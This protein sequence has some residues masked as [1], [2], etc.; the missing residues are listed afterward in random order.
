MRVL[1]VV[2]TDAFAG[3]ER[4]VARLA[5]A[6]SARGH[7]VTVAGGDPGAMAV[8]AP[9][10]RRVAAATV[11]AAAAAVRRAAARTDVVHAHMT[12]AEL[13]T[14]LGLAGLG[15]A[16][17]VVATRH[18]ARRR[19]SGRLGPVVAR[20][21]TH[22]LRAQ[23]A[24][25]R[26]VADRVDGA[27]DGPCIVVPP[28][29]DPAPEPPDAAARSAV[30][31][32]AQRLEAE[33]DTATAVRAFAGSGLAADGWT[34]RVAGDGAQRDEIAR[35]AD[36]LGVRSLVELLGHRGDVDDLMRDAALFLATCPVEGLGLSV[37]EAMRSGLPVV[38]VGA[39]GHL[40]TSGVLDRAPLFDP[41]DHRGAATLLAD[42]AGDLEARRR[43]GREGRTV[44]AGRT[45]D[46]QVE[47]TDAVYRS[48]LRAPVPAERRWA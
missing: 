44:A 40:D 18:F 29:L 19:G 11:P 26:Y 15:D 38:A 45:L 47:G 6:Q 34:L 14:T 9:D 39:G 3:V 32:V 42:L 27:A 17:P 2:V 12:A 25:S 37:L 13:A 4:H 23:L 10:V 16:P 41:G 33:K 1:H 20:A 7:T 30:V 43:L 46:R 31:L 24:I 8:A 35:L 48:V 21:A 28:G 36:D 5:Q 22:R